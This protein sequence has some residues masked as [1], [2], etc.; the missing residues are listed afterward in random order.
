MT[1]SGL[2]ALPVALNLLICASGT[3]GENPSS[4]VKIRCGDGM[5]GKIIAGE[6][7]LRVCTCS[8]RF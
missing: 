6:I 4:K 3:V 5:A 8:K 7:N 1:C 2:R